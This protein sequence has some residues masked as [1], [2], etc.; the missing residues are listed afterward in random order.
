MIRREA[1]GGKYAV[2]MRMKLQP[3]IPTVEHAEEADLGSKVPGIAGDLQQGLSTGMKEQVVNQTFVLQCEREFARQG[4]DGMHVAGGQQFPFT[5]L[6][7][8]QAGVALASWAM[9]V[10]AR[11]VGDGGRRPQPVQRSR[12]PPSAA[13]RQRVMASNT[14]W[15]CQFI[16]LRLRSKNACPAQRIMSAISRRGR[17][18]SCASV[19]LGPNVS[20]SSGLAVALSCRSERCR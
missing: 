4:K 12:C 20:A 11:V 2:D 7:P 5:C 10:S 14:L 8:A 18:M 16:H 3:L 6:E 9:P 1:A 15:C 19:L 13:V 17:L